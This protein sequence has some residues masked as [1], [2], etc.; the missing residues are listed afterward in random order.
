[1]LKQLAIR[2]LVLIEKLTLEFD[3]G[4]T[5]LTGETGAGKS[6]LL[7]AIM[8]IAGERSDASLVRA[9]ADQLSITATFDNINNDVRSFLKE[10]GIEDADDLILR[11]VVDKT[12]K[13]KAFV[14]DE[15][16]TLSLLKQITKELIEI[17]GQFD[18]LL[19]SSQYRSVLDYF[20]DHSTLT[21]NVR[22]A[23]HAMKSAQEA[24]NQLRLKVEDVDD[25]RETLCRSVQEIS[26]LKP[27]KN[28]EQIL[29]AERDQLKNGVVNAKA[30][31]ESVQILNTGLLSQLTQL[32][33]T[34]AKLE[35][36]EELNLQ[37]NRNLIDLNDLEQELRARHYKSDANPERLDAIDERLMTLRTLA[38]KHK[39][40]P[41]E[42]YEIEETLTQELSQ[43]EDIEYQ[44]KILEKDYESAKA[45]YKETCEI[46][47]QSRVTAG[48]SL[49]Q[50]VMQ[51]FPALK[52]ENAQFKVDVI[53]L[54]LEQATIH[55]LDR[56]DY[57]F[58]ANPGTAMHPLAKVA[59][60]GELSRL[61]LALKV[62]LQ[63]KGS[64]TS[65]IFDEIDSGVG[66]ATASAIGA[67]LKKL[68]HHGQVMVITHAPQVA[69]FANYHLKVKKEVRHEAGNEVTHT[70]VDF[71]PDELRI[72]EIARMLSGEN[73]TAEAMTAARSLQEQ[74]SLNA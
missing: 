26:Q 72:S 74:A 2:N 49:T 65:I 47:H 66:G 39:T 63:Q 54:S 20:A 62:S 57:L 70:L 14:N 34:M 45:F 17:H 40:T 30:L 36:E 5:V 32:Q 73:I 44:L 33:K 35:G 16:V 43:L 51:E 7:D 56:V 19:E 6:M 4:L 18:R 52:L 48:K 3:K 29:L 42:L 68:S 12:G 67:R 11:R 53:P 22:N 64:T 21:T 61:M 55:G 1:M 13:S 23:Y 9:G 50:R 58:S 24:L 37:L 25:L 41:D 59:S 27:K 69:S 10:H 71:L 8:L 15:T 46:L 60:G 31:Q 38:R 28:E